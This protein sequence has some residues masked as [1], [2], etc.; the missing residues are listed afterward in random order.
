MTGL[1]MEYHNLARQKNL[2]RPMYGVKALEP[3]SELRQHHSVE[4]M[5]RYYVREI[6][7]VQPQGPY[8]LT[9]YSIG[10][11]YAYAV[12]QEFHRQGQE[13]STL[14]LVDT[15]ANVELSWRLFLRSKAW[16][17]VRRGFFHLWSLIVTKGERS[18]YLAGRWRALLNH[19]PGSNRRGTRANEV[20][21]SSEINGIKPIPYLVDAIKQYQP[22]SYA[23]NLQIFVG[24]D[25]DYVFPHRLFWSALIKGEIKIHK[26]RGDHFSLLDEENAEDFANLLSQVLDQSEAK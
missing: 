7:T 9:G 25:G 2:D 11:W 13:V 21:T 23:G 20:E 5:A 3:N 19:L 6:Q 15:Q 24:D 26:V 4:E 12:A 10:G 1:A 17:L 16:M 8:H 18:K 22:P 14:L